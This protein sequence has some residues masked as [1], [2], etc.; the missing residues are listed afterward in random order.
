MSKAESWRRI[1]GRWA[2]YEVSNRGR[3]RHAR[4]LVQKKLTVQPNGYTAVTFQ[5]G[6][7]QNRQ[8]V[9][10]HVLLAAAF[11]GP[12]PPGQLVRHLD[13]DRS[14]NV[15]GNIAYGTP[16]ENADDARLHGTV[17]RGE[18]NG[19]SKLTEGAVAA[20]RQLRGLIPQTVLATWL[21]VT[22]DVI[23]K[24]QR[25]ETWPASTL[26]MSTDDALRA[27]FMRAARG[28]DPPDLCGALRRA[29]EADQDGDLVVR[30]FI[31]SKES[32]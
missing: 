12:R 15:E 9:R 11:I 31:P 22:Q 27:I 8:T 23:S 1:P 17:C 32:T 28:I 6:G 19:Q 20:L 7:R 24:A 26:Q 10:V 4:T 14:R 30:R 18:Q 2:E 13:G 3:V 29:Y 25:G 16:L 21:G 5:S